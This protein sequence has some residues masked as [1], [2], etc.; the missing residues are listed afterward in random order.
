MG[1]G[2]S[3]KIFALVAIV[4][5]ALAVFGFLIGPIGSAIFH[6]KGPSFLTVTKPEV[7]LPSEGIFHISAFTVTNTLIASWITIIVLFGLFYAATRKMK[8]I[9]GGLQNFAEFI[10]ETMLNFVKGVAGEKQARTL[11]PIVAPIFL[12]VLTNVFLASLM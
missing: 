9:P 5:L 10:I 8:L 1:C 7:E 11:F 12:Y 3:T 2:C 6:T 4:L